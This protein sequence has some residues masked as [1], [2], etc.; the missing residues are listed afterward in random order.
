ME[1]L[2]P[3]IKILENPLIDILVFALILLAGLLLKRFGARFLSRQSFRIVKA[4][5]QNQFSEVFVDLLRKP[6]EQF[7]F[8]IIVYFAFSRLTF[9]EAWH[10]AP[11]SEYGVRWFLLMVW[12]LLFFINIT[13]IFLR[14]I[15]F[16]TY[17]LINRQE[18][19]VTA[20][21]A[22]FLKE[23]VKVVVVIFCIFTALRI[24]FDVNLTALV[25]SLG[26]G[27]LA[28]A[29][30]AQ[31]TLANLLGSFIIY[32]DKPF[33]AGDL[34]ESGDIKGIVEHVGFRTTRIRTPDKSL[35]TV[36]NKKLVDTPLNNITLSEARRVVSDIGLTY[37]SRSEQILSIIE[38]IKQVL[39]NHPQVNDDITVRFKDFGE[40]ALNIYVV[41]FVRGN[42]GMLMLTVKEEV[43]IRIME[44]VEKHGCEFAYPTQ[45]IELKK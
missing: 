28:V 36:P 27:G 41:Y 19:P 35:L 2:N 21:L 24:I 42:D 7:L 43:N 33:K 11:V 14:A 22:N 25:A 8:L 38:D 30:A 12:Q 45:T 18:S 29:L 31:D 10:L 13:R 4:F 6:I 17:V 20:E 26:I 3:E 39:I 1:F 44:I 34:V 15:D 40:S 5:S 23:L 9:P 32:L 37:N 16:F